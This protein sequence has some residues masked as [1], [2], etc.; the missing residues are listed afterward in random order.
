MNNATNSQ[1]DLAERIRTATA[2][3]KEAARALDKGQTEDAARFARLGE[4][5]L[6]GVRRDLDAEE[7]TA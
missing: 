6:D 5:G 4:F 1:H 3:W 2:W 7:V